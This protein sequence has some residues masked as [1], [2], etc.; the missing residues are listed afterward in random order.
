MPV[1]E[2]RWHC[3]ARRG[4]DRGMT[5]TITKLR[6]LTK[7]HVCHCRRQETL[8]ADF[9]HNM[10][11]VPVQIPIFLIA[12]TCEMT[13]SPLRL[14]TLWHFP[15]RQG[16]LWFIR[17]LKHLHCFSC[18]SSLQMLMPTV[19]TIT[20]CTCFNW[21]IEYLQNRCCLQQVSEMSS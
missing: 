8:H 21:M 20:G 17:F 6:R 3:D 18:P 5:E 4:P 9:E 16:L 15:G 2:L 7:K 11:V 12:Q 14:T 13:Q 19:S 1:K 10:T